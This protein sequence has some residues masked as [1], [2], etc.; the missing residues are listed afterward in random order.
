MVPSI[1]VSLMDLGKGSFLGLLRFFLERNR[2]L[3]MIRGGIEVSDEMST[4]RGPHGYRGIWAA[5]PK[6]HNNLWTHHPELSIALQLRHFEEEWQLP[7][8]VRETASLVVA[9]G[10]LVH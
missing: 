9:S 6:W 4:A 1:F 2:S 8:R 10:C 7:R 3:L 5:K